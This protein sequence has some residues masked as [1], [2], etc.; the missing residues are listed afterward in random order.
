MT[1]APGKRV[2]IDPHVHCRDWD[3]AYKATIK[4]VMDIAKSQGVVAI[5]DMPNTSP[6]ITTE[7]LVNKR[8]Q[9]AMDEGCIDGYYLYI[10]VTSNPAQIREAV[11]VIDRNPKVL[12][13]KF[14]TGRSVG[15]LQISTEEGQ[16][17]VHKTLAEIGYTG[18]VA[19]HCE[20]ES[21]YKEELWDPQR[22]YTWNSARPPQSEVESV[23]DQ[24]SFA[25]EYGLKA[26][27]HV[28]HISVP[29]SVM[30]V[31]RARGSIRISCGATP[32]HLALSTEDMQNPEDVVYKVNPPIRD[33]KDVIGLRMLL[34]QGKIDIIETD[35]AP[36]SPQEKEYSKDKPKDSYMSGIQS[37]NS[38]S[39]FI[40]SLL[41]DGFSEDQ[42]KL[43]TYDNVKKIFT[44]IKE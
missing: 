33:P 3:L 34:K 2:H 4:S 9:T 36:H 31:D 28:C 18:V 35:H 24:I 29:E 1:Q 22:P 32:H 11:D 30:L 7:E 20:K 23:S 21:M 6:A 38:Y 44:K 14:Q 26:H 12:G 41:D 19:M 8:L 17:M 10:G 25:K 27:L 16:R 15:Q 39:S 43:L 40:E 37:L 42:I 13:M 5:G